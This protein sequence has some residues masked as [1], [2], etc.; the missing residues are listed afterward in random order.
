MKVLWLAGPLIAT[1]EFII[2]R[3]APAGRSI[4][5]PKQLIF[6]LEEESAMKRVIILGSTLVLVACVVFLG[7][8][9]YAD[10]Q[11][12]Q[13]HVT[14]L[15]TYGGNING[16]DMEGTGTLFANPQTGE[17]NAAARFDRMPQ[18]YALESSSWSLFSISCS[19]GG[20][21]EG[22]AY[23]ILQ[24][25]NG[26]YKS[27]RRV[28]L[29]DERGEQ[30]GDITIAGHFTPIKPTVF[31]ADVKVSGTYRGPMDLIPATGYSLPT[32]PTGERTL[33]GGFTITYQTRGG[34]I[35]TA[36]HEHLYEFEE[37]TRYALQ[38]NVM[39]IRYAADSFWSPETRILRIHGT[40]V[41]KPLKQSV[42]MQ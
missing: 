30:L 14:I 1:L 41:I 42:S 2:G 3:Q 32:Q 25:T 17:F 38:P 18:N 37:G 7:F 36:R 13:E 40:S 6:F 4:I 5:K 28:R 21:G 15:F 31:T 39:E 20:N 22:G 8:K 33:A 12:T 11:K 24:L 29:F 27:V 35:I 19:N 9:G 16:Q 23:N 26:T 34:K 10:A